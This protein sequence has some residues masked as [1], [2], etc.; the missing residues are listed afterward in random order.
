M[1]VTLTVNK[2]CIGKV[3]GIIAPGYGIHLDKECLYYKV[4]KA[5]SLNMPGE[6]D[7]ASYTD[8]CSSYSLIYIAS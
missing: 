1:N 5:V 8:V 3:C 6:K 2:V 4:L 7:W